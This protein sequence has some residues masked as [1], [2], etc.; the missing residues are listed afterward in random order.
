MTCSGKPWRFSFSVTQDRF[1]LVVGPIGFV[2]FNTTSLLPWDEAQRVGGLVQLWGSF[3]TWLEVP[4]GAWEMSL[5]EPIG[6][7]CADAPPF[8]KFYPWLCK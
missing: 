7:R 5:G 1:L 4:G 2:S 6:K 8:L 3:T